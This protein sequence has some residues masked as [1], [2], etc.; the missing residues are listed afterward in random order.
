[1][2]LSIIS[3]AAACLR[4]GGI[5]AF[6]TETVYGLGA[7]AANEAAI[8][9]VFQVKERP[10]DHPLIVHISDVTQLAHWAREVPP[11][12]LKLAAAFWPGALTFVLPKKAHVL[13]CVTGGQDTVGLRMPNHPVALALLQA[14]GGGLV[15]PSANKFTHVSPTTA[16]AVHDELGEAVDIILEG[17]ACDVGIESTILDL[18]G[19]VP[20]ILR[21]GMV[22]PSAISAV[23]NQA[24]AVKDEKTATTRVAGMHPV[25]YAPTTATYLL[26]DTALPTLQTNQSPAV[27]LTHSHINTSSSSW[28]ILSMPQEPVA[29]AHEL[30]QTL[31]KV[32]KQGYRSIFIEALPFGAEWDAIRDRVKRATQV[33]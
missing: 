30:Y 10:Y 23:L 3:Q 9:R 8:R 28:T 33:R 20:L 1:M 26:E 7:D 14:F 18:S 19:D 13:D 2:T 24:V 6:P 31:R 15:G 22:S 12:A 32:D 5:V 21:P 4:A 27:L 17:G 29:Y 11:A 16:A 25:H